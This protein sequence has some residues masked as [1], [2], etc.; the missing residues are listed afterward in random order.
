MRWCLVS[1]P[2]SMLLWL[3]VRIRGVARA[4]QTEK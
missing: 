2:I 3:V 4:D 1:N